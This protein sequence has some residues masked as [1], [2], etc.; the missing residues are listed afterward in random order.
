MGKGTTQETRNLRRIAGTIRVSAVEAATSPDG[1][2]SNYSL[3]MLKMAD[4]L[5]ERADGI[6]R[7]TFAI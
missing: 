4:D 3:H 7:I 5:E 2:F 6:E 1:T